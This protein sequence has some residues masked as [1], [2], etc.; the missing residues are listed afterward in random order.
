MPF[1]YFI[2]GKLC[3]FECICDENK[4]IIINQCIWCQSV[5]CQARS[6]DSVS[7]FST[8]IANPNTIEMNTKTNW[9]NPIFESSYLLKLGSG[10]LLTFEEFNKNEWRKLH[11]NT[12][13]HTHKPNLM[14]ILDI[15]VCM[16]RWKG[17]R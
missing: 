16:K 14:Y 6:C 13:T 3:G 10:F 2:N 1:F 8:E 11:Y 9:I 5:S 12:H 15:N 4:E 7:K 17:N